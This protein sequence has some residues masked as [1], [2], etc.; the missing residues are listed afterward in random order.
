MQICSRLHLLY[1]GTEQ[2][3]GG[4]GAD[5]LGKQFEDERQTRKSEASG[6]FLF[7]NYIHILPP[8]RMR[9]S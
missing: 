2:D 9:Y 4:Y 8:C 6:K 7:Y 5:E 1:L 3:D